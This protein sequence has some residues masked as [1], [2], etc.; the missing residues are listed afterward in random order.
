LAIQRQKIILFKGRNALGSVSGPS[1][2][3]FARGAAMTDYWVSKLFF[4]LHHDPELAGEYRANMS[5]VIDRYQIKPDIRKALLDDDVC[6][7]APLVNA[8]LLRFYF[9]VR[10]MPEPE[11]IAKLRAMNP[12]SGRSMGSISHG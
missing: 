11:F 10:G 8:Y 4:D 3:H 9:Q 12:S 1:V 7:L 5:A 2:L 6:R